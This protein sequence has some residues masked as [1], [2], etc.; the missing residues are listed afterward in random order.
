MLDFP[1]S[2]DVSS[3]VDDE[4]EI[5]EPILVSDRRSVLQMSHRDG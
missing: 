4:D 2:L 1:T 5:E 3:D